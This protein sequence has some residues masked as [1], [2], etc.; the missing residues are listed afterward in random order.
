MK[1]PIPTIHEAV[2][3]L[4]NQ[5]KREKDLRRKSRLHMLYL[6]KSGACQTRLEVAETLAVHRNTI[7]RWL[8][9]YEHGGLNALMTIEE[10]G[11]KPGQKTLPQAVIDSLK[12]RLKE[13]SG[14]RSYGEIQMWLFQTHR[15]AVNYQNGVPY[16]A[17]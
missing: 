12:A 4:E 13:E 15:L 16:C 17:L 14:F 7:G 5:L 3:T 2:K 10:P 11:A 1:R 8:K 6:L 9:R